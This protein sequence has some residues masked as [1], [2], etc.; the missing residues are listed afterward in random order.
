MLIL[1][2]VKLKVLSV[3]KG[4]L[5]SIFVFEYENAYECEYGIPPGSRYF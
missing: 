2:S 3:K 5:S 4:T 1:G